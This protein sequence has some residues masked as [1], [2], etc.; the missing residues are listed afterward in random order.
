[1]AIS[2]AAPSLPT[3]TPYKATY[4][5]MFTATGPI[6]DSGPAA[7]QA[8][9]SASPRPPSRRCRATSCWTEAP[10]SSSSSATRSRRCS[11]IPRPCR[12]PPA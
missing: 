7:V 1:M 12:R 11:P 9:L 2:V 8:L 5:A 10:A 3:S 6:P 4:S